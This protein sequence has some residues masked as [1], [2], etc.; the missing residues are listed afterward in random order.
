MNNSPKNVL[1]INGR[2]LTQPITGVQRY[3][4]EILSSIDK[5]IDSGKILLPDGLKIICLVPK[6]PFFDP[7]WNNIKIKKIGFLRNNLWEQIDLPIYV[8]N[9]ILFSPANIA[10]LFSPNQVTT[11]HDAS[12]FAI[13]EAY[14]LLFRVKYKLIFSYV[15]R[16]AKKI[17][18]DSNFSK[19]EISRY[20][21]INQNKIEI[22]PLGYDHLV[23]T[24]PDFSLNE[25]FSLDEKP[26]FLL[27]GSESRHKNTR[28]VFQANSLLDN[29]RYNIVF[30]GGS[31][32]KIFQ[33]TEKDKS[34]NII[35]VGYVTDG[36]LRALYSKALC[37]IFPSIYEGFGLPVLESLSFGCPVLCSNAASLSEFGEKLVTYFN[38]TD[39]N[40]LSKLMNEQLLK[41][42]KISIDMK[43]LINRYSWENSALKTWKVLSRI[44]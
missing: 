8:N 42:P 4:R 9:N 20:C 31:F 21:K 7:N 24:Q 28:L 26:Y 18:T 25:N 35:E 23:H 43:M 19:K 29:N 5:L 10:P 11:F 16:K 15:G 39:P 40:E 3:S 37:F 22:I 27:V 44:I 32:S 1:F 38:P 41:P 36:Q 30:V 34:N 6:Q 12:V 2:F 33:K 17:I 14:S 13:P